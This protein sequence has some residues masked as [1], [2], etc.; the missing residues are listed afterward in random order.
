MERESW[1]S[2]AAYRHVERLDAHGIA[3]EYLRRNPDYIRD[4]LGRGADEQSTD[5]GLRRWGLYFR[6]RSEPSGD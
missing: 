5:D 4:C 1:R 2:A 3:Y 6:R